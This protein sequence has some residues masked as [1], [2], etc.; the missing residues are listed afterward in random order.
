MHKN[1]NL[2]I[3]IYNSNILNTIWMLTSRLLVFKLC[4]IHLID[5]EMT[6]HSNILAWEVPWT[7]EPGGLQSIGLQ[8]VG[9]DLVITHTH[10]FN[11]LCSFNKDTTWLRL[12]SCPEFLLFLMSL[13]NLWLHFIWIWLH[14]TLE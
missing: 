14:N 3:F 7:E 5:K 4:C 6:V 8:R 12:D 2:S 1:T 9:H 10:S 11:G 13:S